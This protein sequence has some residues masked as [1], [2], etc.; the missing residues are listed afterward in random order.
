VR[1][2]RGDLLCL[3]SLRMAKRLLVETDKRLLWKLAWSSLSGMLLPPSVLFH[4]KNR[5]TAK[6]ASSSNTVVRKTIVLSTDRRWRGS[7]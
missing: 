7:A 6:P 2:T 4:S 3:Y 1:L 5:I